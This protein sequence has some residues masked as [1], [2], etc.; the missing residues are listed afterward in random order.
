MKIKRKMFIYLLMII[1]I[2]LIINTLVI[3]PNNH[4][5]K[6]NIRIWVEDKY[7]SYFTS[8]AKE[9][10]ENN[11]KVDIEVVSVNQE[12]YL[13]KIVNTNSNELPSIVHL[14]FKELNSIRDKISFTNEN[15]E[16]IDTYN[17]NFNSSRL[18]EVKIKDKYYAIPF[19]SNPIAIYLRS[20]ILDNFGYKVDDINS[21]SNLIDIGKDIYIKSNGEINIFSSQDELNIRLLLAAQL[22]NYEEKNYKNNEIINI[23]NLIYNE[24]FITDNN[25]LCRIGSIN[26]YKELAN[27]NIEGIWECKNPPN[28]NI[29]EN[30]FYDVGGENLVA[31]NTDNN[32][33]AIK[34][35]ISYAATNKELLSKEMLNYNFVPSS[36]YSLRMKYI[37]EESSKVDGNSPFLILSNIVEK[38]PEIKNFDKFNEIIYDL[39]N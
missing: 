33:E 19:T 8:I 5:V 17:K 28:F 10:E 2:V 36:L 18:E 3:R 35:F 11:K 12:D 14:D 7:Y 23:I 26:F 30:R 22:V 25:A 15:S 21:W 38:A 34:S 27:E 37:S 9:F 13:Y 20:D 31:L 4:I 29:G 24:S 32:E 39:Y 6:G 1:F 16:I